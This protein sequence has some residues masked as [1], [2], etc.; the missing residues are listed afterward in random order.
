MTTGTCVESYHDTAN[1]AYGGPHAT[2]DALADVASGLMNGLQQQARRAMSRVCGNPNNPH[3]IKDGTPDVMGYHDRSEI[4]NYWAYADHYVLQDHMFE[5]ENSWSL[6][7][8]LALVSGWSAQCSI[9]RNPLSCDS[10]LTAPFGATN[11]SGNTDYPWTDLT[12]VLHRHHV[13]WRYYVGKGEQ[14][15]C[16]AAGMF[17]A[18]K[19]QSAATPNI[20]NPLARFDT[21]RANGQLDNIQTV[22]K[23]ISAA[24]KGRLPNAA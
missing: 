17:C 11:S 19:M 13:S 21:V 4:P 18:P 9:P 6:P 3:C 23:L 7:A 12:Y 16:S 10:T 2:S 20:W 22:P 5:S 8:H 1:L 24:Q 14:P 15:D